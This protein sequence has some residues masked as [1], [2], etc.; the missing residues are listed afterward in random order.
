MVTR[1]NSTTRGWARPFIADQTDLEGLRAALDAIG[2]T[3][4]SGIVANAGISTDRDLTSKQGYELTFAVNVLS[5]Q[6]ILRT[7]GEQL[8]EGGRIVIV[9]SGVHDPHNQLARRAGVPIP[10]WIGTRALALANLPPSQGHGFEDGRLRYS[11]SKLGNIL[12]ARGIQRW[13]REQGRDVDVFAID[14]GLMVDTQLARD[15]TLLQRV[16]LKVIGRLATPFV[17]N[18]RT[19]AESAGHIASLLLDDDWSGR[20][21]AYLDGDQVRP[22][23]SDAQSDELMQELWDACPQLLAVD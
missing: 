15:Y 4:L 11:T 14:P 2:E 22:P 13:L 16:V 1:I 9:S 23:S 17:A 7:L 21:F 8:D 18:M 19:S 3:R 20:G 6:L 12:Q 10:K 5:H